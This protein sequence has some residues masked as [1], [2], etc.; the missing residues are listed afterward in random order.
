MYTH[1]PTPIGYMTI[2]SFCTVDGRATCR[3]RSPLAPL[4]PGANT[5]NKAEGTEGEAELR[6]L[7]KLLKNQSRLIDS[8]RSMDVDRDGVISIE[9]FRTA[10]EAMDV[11]LTD[12]QMETLI[13]SIDV[14]NDGELDMQVNESTFNIAY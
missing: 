8:I 5:R 14:D 9:E 10:V 11:G 12:V 6:L 3:F 1:I 2:Y 13:R 4:I 7:R